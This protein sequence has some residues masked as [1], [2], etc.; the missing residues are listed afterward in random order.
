MNISTSTKLSLLSLFFSL[1]TNISNAAESQLVTLQP[2][3][4]S[5]TLS[6]FTRARRSIPIAS[7]IS[8]KVTHIYADIGQSIPDN[9]IF[10]CL[11]KTF[12]KLDIANT[13]NSIA[14]HGIDLKYLSKQVNRHKKLVQSNSAALSVLDDL[15]RQRGNAYR[16]IQREK[17]QKQKLEETKKRH[18]IKA[19]KSWK[20]TQRNIEVGQWITQGTPIAQADDYAQLLIPL[21]LTSEELK[22]LEAKKDKFTIFFPEYEQHA[23]ATIE[24]ISPAFDEQSHK[25]RVDLLIADTATFYRGG[26]RAELTLEVSDKLNSFIIPN[27]ALDERFEEVWITRKN[28]EKIRVMLLGRL[29]NGQVKISSPKIK[30]GDQFKR[31]RL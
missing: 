29:K 9:G 5:I 31:L 8:G 12:I 13:V 4:Q 2:S 1:T 26:I 23:P 17:I 19:P 15:T 27:Q 16:A 11:D 28:G 20:V 18:C 21:T 6:G 10:A 30:R 3:S 22:A 24:H 7:E 14:Q 25:I